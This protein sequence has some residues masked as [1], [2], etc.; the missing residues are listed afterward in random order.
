MGLAGFPEAGSQI[1]RKSDGVL[2]EIY[3]TAP[4]DKLFVR[5][6][7]SM[8]GAYHREDCNPD[9]FERT[10]ELTGARLSPPRETHVAIALIS[11]TVLVFFGFVLHNTSFP[12]IGY[13]PYKPVAADNPAVLDSSQALKAKYGLEAAEACA[14]GS[15]EYIRSITHHR[16][17]WEASDDLL[18]RFDRFSPT[19]SSPGVLTL[20]SNKASV[21]N[22]FGLFHPIEI[23]CNYDTQIHEVLSY[24]GGDAGE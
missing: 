20:L 11:L 18:P 1:R 9:Q 2:G 23:A 4:P 22:G 24:E 5:W 7:A 12:Y 16:F 13:D 15:D 21:S 8:P 17:H 19:I 14:V 3:G 6:A 10:W